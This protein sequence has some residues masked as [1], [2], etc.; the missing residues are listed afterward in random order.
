MVLELPALFEERAYGKHCVG[1]A[2]SFAGSITKT[3]IFGTSKQVNRWLARS[4]TC[5]RSRGTAFGNL[6]I[7]FLQKRRPIHDYCDRHAGLADR[8]GHE[9]VAIFANLKLL[10][11]DLSFKQ[12]FGRARFEAAIRSALHIGGHESSVAA[13]EIQFL[14][15]MTPN[16]KRS[17][18]RRYCPFASLLGKCLNVHLVAPSFIGSVRKPL[19]AGRETGCF[20]V[21]SSV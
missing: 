18:G 10:V 3:P 20:V 9:E 16:R 15:I 17:A 12:G 19:P 8:R 1:S 5:G 14:A 11:V 7:S 13:Q 21:E 6:T 4:T 2:N